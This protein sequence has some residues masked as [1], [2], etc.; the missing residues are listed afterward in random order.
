MLKSTL[1]IFDA[2]QIERLNA[3]LPVHLRQTNIADKYRK[4]Q[5]AMG[6]DSAEEMFRNASSYLDSKEV[7]EMLQVPLG[8][9]QYQNFTMHDS[10]SL[11]D[12]MMRIDYKTFMVDD[13]L[14]KVDRATM[15]VSLEGREPLL[16]HRI[17]EY[18]A[19]VPDTLKYKN[20]QGKYLERQILYKHIPASLVD[21][22]KAGFQ[23]PLAEWL[24]GELKPLVEKYLD[25]SSLDSEVFNVNYV[26]SVKK[27]FEAGDTQYATMIWFILM[28]E[29][30]K[31]KWFV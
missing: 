29:M 19:R 9:T 10:L 15:S 22:P 17:I 12:N 20:G 23:V 16:D 28:Y 5:R 2:P 26:D 8:D 31:E 14:T 27:A 24:G 30:W 25:P 21:K 1:E 3:F 6:S 11:L 7:E 4:F 13:V 18:M